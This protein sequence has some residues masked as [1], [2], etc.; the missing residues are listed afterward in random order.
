VLGFCRAPPPMLALQSDRQ[1]G[2]MTSAD[3]TIRKPCQKSDAGHTK[4]KAEN[5]RSISKCE[6]AALVSFPGW[7]FLQPR[8]RKNRLSIDL[9]STGR[10]GSCTLQSSCLLLATH[11]IGPRTGGERCFELVPSKYVLFLALSTKFHGGE[12]VCNLPRI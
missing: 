10:F 3:C 4:C 7:L 11:L 1:D 12:H 2:R 9:H 5:C 8:L 6:V